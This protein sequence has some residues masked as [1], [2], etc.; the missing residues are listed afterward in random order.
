MKFMERNFFKKCSMIALALLCVLCGCQNTTKRSDSKT[1]QSAVEKKSDPVQKEKGI[2]CLSTTNNRVVDESG[3]PYVIKGISTHGLAWFPEIVNE[4][5]FSNFKNDF[6][7][8][9]VRLAMYTAESGGYCTDGYPQKLESLIDRGIKL[10]QSLNLYCVVDWHIL[11]DQNPLEH[12]DS[13]KGFFEKMARQYGK[14]P[15]VIFEICNEPNGSTTWQ[16]VSEYANEIIP[17]I[18]KYSDTLILVGTPN[19][20]QDIEQAA[21]SPLSFKNVAYTL[22]FYAAT[23]KD[24]LRAKYEQVVNEI[25]IVV[26]EFGICDASGNGAIDEESGNTWIRLLNKY[27][28]GRILWNASNKDE[29]SSI[30]KPGTNLD[31]WTTADLTPSGQ[32]LLAQNKA[33]TPVKKISPIQSTSTQGKATLSF[34]SSNTWTEK[35]K[36]VVQLEGT[37]DNASPDAITSWTFTVQ[38]PEAVQVSDHWNCDIQR[39]D[40]QTIQIT[41]LDYNGKVD[42]GQSISDIGLI[43]QSDQSI[44][45][46]QIQVK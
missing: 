3:N 31:D 20:S 9:T 38:F 5:S 4:K 27:D 10:C 32:W 45:V 6:G 37:L 22:H 7:L 35:N 44:Q 14:L 41:N 1:K 29:S 13:A 39:M 2:S 23:H 21:Q 17:V 28:T 11:S 36:P 8:N 43:V 46:D 16:E 24:D 12:L 34:Q 40:D 42:A 18:R 15:N 30:L 19:W 26:S 33:A 25:P